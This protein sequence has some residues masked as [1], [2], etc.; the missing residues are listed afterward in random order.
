MPEDPG[1]LEVLTSY[2][3][4]G[5]EHIASGLDHLLFV[6]ALLL[7]IRKPWTLFGAVTAF[8]IAHSITLAAAALGWAR[9]PGPPVEA[10]I[11]LSIMFLA[12]EI[13]QRDPNKPRL[14]ER[15]PWAVC[16]FFGLIH[17]LGFGSALQ[18]IGLPQS[19]VALALLSFNIGVEV[20]QILFILAVVAIWQ[21]AKRLIPATL[22][23]ASQPMRAGNAFVPYAIGCVA[24]FWFVERLAGF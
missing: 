7:L 6:F 21:V 12:A 4:L 3:W 14:S 23:S 19:E 10:V 15:A 24:A 11:A 8:T 17:G 13:L 20:G 5:L 16:F 9:V 18:E 1:A 22:N 2:F